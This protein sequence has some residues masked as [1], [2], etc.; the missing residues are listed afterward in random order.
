M[1]AEYITPSV[2]NLQDVPPH[3][4]ALEDEPEQPRP[5]NY[6]PVDVKTPKQLTIFEPRQHPI[7]KPAALHGLV[8][9]IV[10]AATESSEVD[11]AAVV[12][13]FLTYFGA[14]I[15]D[16]SFIR[17]GE[18]RHPARL[19]SAIVG[20]SSRARKG[21]SVG[22]VVRIMKEACANVR[23][24]DG[25]IASGEGIIQ[26]VRDPSDEKD[27]EGYP[28]DCGVNDKRIIVIEEEMAAM[29]A[30]MK[31]TGNTL[32]AVIRKLFDDGNVDP[33][34]KNNHIKTSGAHVCMVCHIT[35][36]ELSDMLE[37][38]ELFNG[39]A[40]RYTWWCARRQRLE[41]NPLPMDDDL[42]KAIAS[43]LQ[44]AIDYGKRA[45]EIKFSDDAKV[46]WEKLYRVISIDEPGLVGVV[47]SRAEAQVVRLALT[48]SLL[49]SSKTINMVH[50]EAALAA[51]QYCKD[52]ATFIFGSNSSAMAEQKRRILQALS[53]GP[54]SITELR[55]ALSNHISGDVL[56]SHLDDFQAAG[57]AT[58]HKVKT[59]GRPATMWSIT[60]GFELPE[61]YLSGR[62]EENEDVA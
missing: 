57:V 47:T 46:A 13:T 55:E 6:S 15:G 16:Y 28:E 49:D 62:E 33:L 34:T 5:K 14:E 8:G 39:F 35:R 59:A 12:A 4:P 51:W 2:P 44:K 32:S 40:N 11:P 38:K 26:Q 53:S 27:D 30:A 10:Q 29:L 60:K 56:G 9:E 43:K 58:Q 48:Y 54:K 21:T 42:V 3:V 50:L 52:S 31:R 17:R 20:A 45:G 1:S 36:F 19:F 25:P 22:P 61:I 7:L 23:K 37:Q 18:D 41:A 24:V